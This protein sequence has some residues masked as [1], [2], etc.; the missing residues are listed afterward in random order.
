MNDWHKIGDAGIGGAVYAAPVG[1]PARL[2]ARPAR[3]G[4]V[5][6]GI[7][8]HGGLVG[9]PYASEGQALHWLQHQRRELSGM[10]IP[11]EFHPVLV[12]RRIETITGSWKPLYE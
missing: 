5:E 8:N 2:P 7:Q 11:E 1:T 10:G 9:E 3:H 12:T 4:R 6:F